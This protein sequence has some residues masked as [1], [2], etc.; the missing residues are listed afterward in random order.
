M[1][2]KRSLWKLALVVP[3]SF[4]LLGAGGCASV[5]GAG[6]PA[7]DL[8]GLSGEVNQRVEKGRYPGA[9]YAVAKGERTLALQA[10]GKADITTRAPM[11]P[12]SIFRLM[13][14]TKPVTAVATMILVE[15]GMLDLDAP[16]SRYLPE[17][18]TFGVEGAPQLTLRHLLTHTSG[19]GF[20]KI[21]TKTPTL[22]ERARE[23]ATR[24]MPMP[25]GESW[26]YSGVDG[27]DV[28]AR[29]IEVVAGEPYGGFV[30]R[31]IFDPLGMV[32]TTYAL[33]AQQQARLVG[34]YQAKDGV[35]DKG[36]APFPEFAYASGGAGL[37]STVPDFMRFSQMLAGG[38]KRGS[39]QIL[40][41]RSV[42]ELGKSQLPPGFKGLPPGIGAGLLM[43]VVVDPAAAGSPL[44]A[45]AFGWSGAYG[46]H[47]WIEPSSGVS[48]VWMINLTN[49]GG[50]GS[51]DA[52]DFERL[53]EEA[54]SADR[55]CRA[56]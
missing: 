52:L 48:A 40:T 2:S 23:I 47:F 14:M 22:A 25:V 28:V 53:V 41:T 56:N 39:V 38:G 30:K 7:A 3:I 35:I 46:T 44:P 34:L 51:P 21:P 50:A 29:V 26:A 12:D 5:A 15:E 24:K 31:R 18:S 9:V 11:R 55:R 43:R 4:A 49:A 17:F 42:E 20:G 45:G 6:A 33:T 32:D 16:V 37:Y 8:G 27:P 13:S 36:V 10:L 54:C 1:A 19:I